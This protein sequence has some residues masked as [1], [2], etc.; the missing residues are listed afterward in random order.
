MVFQKKKLEKT[1]RV[2]LRLKEAREA[3]GISIA[4]VA[5][6]TK[7]RP[8][9]VRALEECRFTDIP[10]AV[11]YQK[12]FIRRYAEAIGLKAPG[13]LQQFT[14]EEAPAPAR[15]SRPQ[16]I[17]RWRQNLPALLKGISAALAV[18]GLISYLGW[19][20]RSIVTPPALAVFTPPDGFVTTHPDLLIYGETAKE[21]QVYINGQKITTDREGQFK[22]TLS[23]SPGINRLEITAKKRHGKTSQST[24][25]V[26][27]KVTERLTLNEKLGTGN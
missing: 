1:K 9:Y 21:A 3:A 18:L 5:Q 8:A 6:K 11:I 19:Q 24:R 15:H 27:L 7:I 13:L 25:H 17:R 16:P 12:H 20:V 14:S 22:E 10:Y 2:C 4:E 23:L 26:I